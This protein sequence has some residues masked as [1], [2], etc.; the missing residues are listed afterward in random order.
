[1]KY[2]SPVYFSV[3]VKE[4]ESGWLITVVFA[5]IRPEFSAAHTSLINSS[6]SAIKL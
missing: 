3:D 5:L 6:L 1:M 2:I 4:E